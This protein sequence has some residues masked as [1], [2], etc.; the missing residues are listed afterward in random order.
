MFLF[1][2]FKVSLCCYDLNDNTSS[3]IAY[4]VMAKDAIVCAYALMQSHLQ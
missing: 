4:Y 2:F 3:W 1:P